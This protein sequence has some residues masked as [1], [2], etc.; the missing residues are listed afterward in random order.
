V[1]RGTAWMLMIVTGL[2]LW[3]GIVKAILWCLE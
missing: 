1:I 2:L 3:A